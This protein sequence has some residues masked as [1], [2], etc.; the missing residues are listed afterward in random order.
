MKRGKPLDFHSFRRAYNTALAGANMNVQIAMRLA[1]HRSASTH[2]RY[3]LFTDELSALAQAL[4]VLLKAPPVP[5]L[6]LRRFD[7]PRNLPARPGRR[8]SNRI[9]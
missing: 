9:E 4:P 3:M 7:A 6:D 8:V 2:M 5:K 1:G